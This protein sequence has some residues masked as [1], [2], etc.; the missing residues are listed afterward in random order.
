M[1]LLRAVQTKHIRV[2][3]HIVVKV[4]VIV[5]MALFLA[6]FVHILGFNWSYFLLNEL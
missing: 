5:S 3:A 2:D 6:L 1:H 4:I